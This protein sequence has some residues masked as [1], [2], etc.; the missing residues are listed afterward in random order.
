MLGAFTC[1]EGFVVRLI[2]GLFI[3]I[4]DGAN[5]GFGV[6]PYLVCWL[7]TRVA[8]GADVTASV[9]SFIRQ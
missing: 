3:W 6:D 4:V 7:G 5:D 8:V 9:S 2:S 1:I